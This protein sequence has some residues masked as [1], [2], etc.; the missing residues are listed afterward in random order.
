MSKTT[1]R[2]Y[3]TPEAS[4]EARTQWRGDCLVWL[5]AVNENG[6]GIIWDGKRTVRV[7]RWNWECHHGPIPVGADIDHRCG[8]RLCCNPDHLRLATR[9]QNMENLTTLYRNNTSGIRGV[10][11]DPR[12]SKWRVRVKHN[13]REAWG[14]Y[15][16]DQAEAEAAAVALRNSLFTHN[17]LDRMET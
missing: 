11:W 10:S 8:V 5:G 14:G 3:P 2:N 1:R 15:F 16:E 4:L 9:K 17:D 7:H 13:Y 6:Y 12:Y